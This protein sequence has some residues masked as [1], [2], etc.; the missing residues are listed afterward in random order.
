MRRPTG[1]KNGT[2]RESFA[3]VDAIRD[4]T[5]LAQGNPTE[6]QSLVE[7]FRECPDWQHAS[8]IVRDAIQASFR[9]R[10]R[11]RLAPPPGWLHPL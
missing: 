5:A 6:Q 8:T 9:A 3:N 1:K 2:L 7:R 11:S 4:L 10:G